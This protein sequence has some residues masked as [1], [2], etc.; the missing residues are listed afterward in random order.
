MKIFANKK[1][2]FLFVGL[3][4]LIFLIPHISFAGFFES[5]AKIISSAV[6][7][8]VNFLVG[9]LISLLI[10]VFVSIAQYN[11]FIGSAAVSKGWIIIRDVLNMFFVIGVLI[12]AFSTVLGIQ[13][14]H[15]KRILL[16]LLIAAVLV[17]FSKLICGIFI[18]ISQILML[19]FVSAFKEVA[20]G[21]LIEMMGLQGLLDL[22]NTSDIAENIGAGEIV[23]AT[24]LAL[25]MAVVSV[26]VLAVIVMILILRIIWIWFLVVLSPFAFVASVFPSTKGYGR[27]W[28]DNFTKQIIVGPALAFCLWLSFAVVQEGDLAQGTNI[29]QGTY[30]SQGQGEAGQQI[31]EAASPQYLLNF[32]LGI[33]MLVGSLMV[34]ENLGVAGSNLARKARS[35]ITAYA[36]GKKG[37]LKG[38]KERAKKVGRVAKGTAQDAAGA[39]IKMPG[40]L[41]K[42]GLKNLGRKWQR[43]G[44]KFGKAAGKV[45]ET[46]AAPVKNIQKLKA[47]AQDKLAEFAEKRNARIRKR[48]EIRSSDEY[49]NEDERKDALKGVGGS[50][51]LDSV[52]SHFTEVYKGGGGLSDRQAI[53][54]AQTEKIKKVINRLKDRGASEDELKILQD[55]GSK[56]QNQA[57]SIMLAERGKINDINTFQNADKSLSSLLELR[58]EFRKYAKKN[59]DSNILK[60][61]VYNGFKNGIGDLKKIIKDIKSGDLNAAKF[62]EGL[63]DDDFNT[64]QDIEGENGEAAINVLLNQLDKG[65]FEKFGQK[66]SRTTKG[67]KRLNT[68]SEDIEVANLDSEKKRQTFVKATGRTDKVL[69]SFDELDLPEDEIEEKKNEFVKRHKKTIL[70]NTS[71]KAME[72]Q[73]TISTILENSNS[74]DVKGLSKE[75]KDQFLTTLKE[76]LINGFNA[77]GDTSETAKNA[78]LIYTKV[79]KDISGAYEGATDSVKDELKLLIENGDIK[80]ED[81]G[82][83]KAADM[84]NPDILR[85]IG[86]KLNA[87]QVVKIA[88][89]NNALAKKI[90]KARYDNGLITDFERDNEWTKEWIDE[91]G[92]PGGGIV[93]P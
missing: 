45:T 71:K 4:A 73:A 44:G 49:S 74:E 20:A 69:K 51:I 6:L 62:I 75:V 12:I 1:R 81:I 52:S 84:T 43:G 2:I 18:D 16:S 58:R 77:S 46:M 30:Q 76:D 66:M 26:V 72:D 87:P 63:G 3:I 65:T 56:T 23:G 83:N 27:T 85:I 60:E 31:S 39:A 82:N 40:R 10:K 24:L 25:I 11:N 36:K 35:N 37:P 54:A 79:K 5:V 19:T 17:N 67:E 41:A 42:T 59:M 80:T 78:R 91:W 50:A 7:S 32:M 33:G 29:E 86:E 28:W 64:L 8:V 68:M 38:V 93:T 34:A 89:E 48:Q 57:A 53:S 15:Y 55:R 92:G 14:Y 61:G 90:E 47:N 13:K 22:K 9:W 70:S 88:K 21:N